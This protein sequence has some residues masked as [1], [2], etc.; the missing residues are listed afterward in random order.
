LWTFACPNF[1]KTSLKSRPIAHIQ[2]LLPV[3]THEIKHSFIYFHILF[4]L[5]YVLYMYVYTRND[6]RRRWLGNKG[7]ELGICVREIHYMLCIIFPNNENMDYNSS[8]RALAWREIWVGSWFG[9]GGIYL[10]IHVH[11]HSVKTIGFKRNPSGR[12][13]ICEYAH[14]PSYRWSNGSHPEISQMCCIIDL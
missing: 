13:R 7:K 8:F 6:A 5:I 11:A 3:C 1:I 12:R 10:Y 4:L 9:G 14:T 2:Y